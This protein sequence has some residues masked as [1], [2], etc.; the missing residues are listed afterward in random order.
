MCELCEIITHKKNNG[1]SFRR[2]H[3]LRD[4]RV[5]K[6]CL[7]R[8][9]AKLILEICTY[10]STPIRISVVTENHARKDV[11]ECLFED[12]YREFTLIL[13]EAHISRTSGFL[14]QQVSFRPLTVE[15]NCDLVDG[16]IFGR[17]ELTRAQ[18]VQMEKI[19]KTGFLLFGSLLI[20]KETLDLSTA[21]VSGIRFRANRRRGESDI[22]G[23]DR[24][25][26]R[27]DVSA[28]GVDGYVFAVVL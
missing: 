7:V 23:K 18:V 17:V 14:V 5:F 15:A 9:C 19:Q 6:K 4:E 3:Y 1:Q 22:L 8:N 26:E 21:G 28:R 11:S 10:F 25:Y 24:T 20:D 2:A 27:C 12:G 13:Q 16:R